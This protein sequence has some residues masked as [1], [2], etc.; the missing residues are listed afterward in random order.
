VGRQDPGEKVRDYLTAALDPAAADRASDAIGTLIRLRR[1]RAG[2]QHTGARP[3]AVSA[4]GEIGLAFPLPSWAYAWTHIAWLAK[5]ALDAIRE[6]VHA[7][8]ALP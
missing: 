4:F 8:I 6:E 2:G 1:I 3:R 5:D 7:G